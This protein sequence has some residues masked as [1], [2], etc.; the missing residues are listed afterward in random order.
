MGECYSLQ[1]SPSGLNGIFSA[2]VNVI[3]RHVAERFVIAP[4]VVVLVR[5]KE[6]EV[7]RD[8]DQEKVYNRLNNIDKTLSAIDAKMGIMVNGR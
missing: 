4:A 2:E 6:I 3:G 5:I 1:S 7:R 8:E